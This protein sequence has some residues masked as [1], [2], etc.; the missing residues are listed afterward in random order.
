MEKKH[1]NFI[2]IGMAVLFLMISM[3]MCSTCST[4]R[5][6]AEVQA[7]QRSADS[8]SAINDAVMVQRF[9]L[10]LQMLQPQVVNQFLALFNA[11]KYKSEIELNNAKINALNMQIKNLNE[12]NDT[13]KAD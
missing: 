3:N 4:T 1:F 10:Q 7:S 9:E 5:K 6:V 13:T 8:L 11:E 2:M 12:K